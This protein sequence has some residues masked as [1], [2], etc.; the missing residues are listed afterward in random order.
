MSLPRILYVC[1]ISDTDGT[2]Y[3]S[4]GRDILD[5]MSDDGPTLVGLYELKTT[6]KYRRIVKLENVGARG[7]KP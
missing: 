2:K 6:G 5:L 4:V 3:L 1:E 7:K